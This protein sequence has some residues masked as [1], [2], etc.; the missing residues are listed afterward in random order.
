MST[1]AK[2][3]GD[4][5]DLSRPRDLVSEAK[6]KGKEFVKSTVGKETALKVAGKLGIDLR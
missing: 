5:Y 4:F 6:R 2:V 1:D 3:I